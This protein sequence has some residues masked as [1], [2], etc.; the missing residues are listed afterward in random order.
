MDADFM[1]ELERLGPDADYAP[2]SLA[3]A[4]S[5][6]RRLARSH[7]ENF[8]VATMLLP[9]RLVPH[10]HAIYAYCRYADDLGDE[11]GG[12]QRTLDL[13][14]WW[15]TELLR[16]C[17]GEPR[18][19]IMVA[20]LP[21]IRRFAIPQSPFL[22]LIRAFEQDQTVTRYDTYDQLLGYCR[23]SANPVGRLVLHLCECHDERTGPLSDA[24]C[25]GLQLANFWQDVR[26]DLEIGRVYLPREDRERFGYS[27]D[28]LTTRRF[29]PAFR[30][31][32]RFES[33][34][35]AELFREGEAL[36][37]LVPRDVRADIELFIRGGQ[38]ILRNIAAVDYDVW[39][40][41]PTVS[42]REKVGLLGRLIWKK[43]VA[44][45]W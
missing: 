36:L 21:T 33:D 37:P 24:V 32:L 45:F 3:A 12:G 34:R 41:R 18:H 6:V 13:L 23:D 42:K 25:T 29:T 1:R 16:C 30:E 43:L 28:D 7:Y 11:T 5:Y 40:T 38:A 19:P 8:S 2:W 27:D 39:R 31:L 4:Q 26:R 44:A 35:A 20:L 15:R 14:A 9:R 17:D 10:F 22:D